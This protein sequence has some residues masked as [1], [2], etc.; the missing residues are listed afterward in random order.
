MIIS[1]IA[2]IMINLPI[3]CIYISMKI[4]LFNALIRVYADTV[5]PE[6]QFRFTKKRGGHISAP[7]STQHFF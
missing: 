1:K 2:I 3:C 7:T 4:H 5:V 6:R